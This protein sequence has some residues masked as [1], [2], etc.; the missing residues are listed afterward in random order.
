MNEKIINKRWGYTRKELKQFRKDYD[1][2][3]KETQDKLQEIFT[4]YNITYD[5]LYK[6]IS[7]NDKQRLKRKIN[8]WKKMGIYKGYFEFR[9]EELMKGK[10]TYRD[11][12]EILLYGAYAEEEKELDFKIKTLFSNVAL[13][14]Y[15]QG[16][17]ELK[18]KKKSII[19]AYILSSFGIMLID[20]YIWQNYID[21]LV[22]TNM[23]EILKQYLILL[24]QGKELNAYSKLIQQILDM[25]RNRLIS[26]SDDKYSGGL[27]K[28]TT[29]LG[30]EAY[31]EASDFKD[32]PVVFIS[33]LCENVTEMCKYMDGMIFYT[34]SNNTFKRPM[35]RTKNDL[36]IEEVSVNGL[37][38]GIN[39][40]PINQHFHWCH[41]TISYQVDKDIKELKR[42]IFGIGKLTF[43]DSV[44]YE[45][46]EDLDKVIPLINIPQK[47]NDKCDSVYKKYKENGFENLTLVDMKTYES[48]GNIST[49]KSRYKVNFSKEQEMLMTELDNNSI[50]A[51]HNHPSNSTFSRGDINMILENNEIGG[52]I[53]TTEKYNYY[54]KP[55][56]KVLKATRENKENFNEY[57][58]WS[59]SYINDQISE[60]HSGLSYNNSMHLAYSLFFKK[61]GWEYGREKKNRNR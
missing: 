6:T 13:N 27:D 23:Q 32:V 17:E 46:D 53:V 48:I 36:V 37:V 44:L 20:G 43:N 14:C 11:L 8:Q 19:P 59:L 22:L 24:Q 18:K 25:Q 31:L 39:L 51:I 42:D 26:V 60:E 47:L 35:G 29:A 45:D 1:K 21:A 2:L 56:A 9:V 40:P 15:N 7:Y 50:I 34:R 3:N 10:I 61:I 33:D 4:S 41:S 52:I 54:L 12:I 57:F 58:D 28:Y 38:P 49:D 55:N 30:N 5:K 16:R